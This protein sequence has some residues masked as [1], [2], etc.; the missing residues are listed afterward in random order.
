MRAALVAL[1]VVAVV[2]CGGSSLPAAVTSVRSNPCDYLSTSD[3]QSTIG[4]K[5]TGYRSGP[6][7][8]YR[9]LRGNTCQVTVAAGADQYGA[10]K[11]AA[12]KYGA[13]ETIPAGDHGF[14]SAESTAPGVWVFDFGLEKNGTFAG[15]LCGARFGASNPRPQAE[16]LAS[17]IAS[18][19]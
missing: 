4:L 8:A 15:A 19:L 7:C 1:V 18:R 17:L 3:F 2:S 9:D 10:S 14:Y 6:S 16:R 11:A 12:A 13:V 5:L